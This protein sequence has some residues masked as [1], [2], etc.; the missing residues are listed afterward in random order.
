[1]LS[2]LNSY[3]LQWILYNC[4][5][6]QGN[7]WNQL[8]SDCHNRSMLSRIQITLLR[9]K[10]NLCI[11]TY[12]IFYAFQLNDSLNWIIHDFNYNAKAAIILVSNYIPRMLLPLNLSCGC[13][14]P[15][16]S[17]CTYIQHVFY[18]SLRSVTASLEMLQDIFHHFYWF[19]L[20]KFHT[21]Q[22]FY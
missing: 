21:F 7:R 19:N 8:T 2:I 10:C 22:S 6:T 5:V 1:M 13:L 16:L 17:I 11:P 9:H 14:D 20:S 12:S 4:S 15:V 18:Y 3:G